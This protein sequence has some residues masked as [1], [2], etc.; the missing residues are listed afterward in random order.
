MNVIQHIKLYKKHWK[1]IFGII[2]I[3]M[4]SSALFAMTKDKVQYNST[5]FLTIGNQ[6][7][8]ESTGYEELQ[9]ADQLTETL[10]GWFRNPAFI[11]EIEEKSKIPANLS[12]RKQEKQNLLITFTSKNE[13]NAKKVAKTT[14]SQIEK[15]LD[16]YNE[17]MHSSFKVA[18]SS[19][20]TEKKETKVIIYIII[21]LILGS[22]LAIGS[23]YLYELIFNSITVHNKK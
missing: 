23:T 16:Q 3:T 8:Q 10:Q 14:I 2:I 13:E 19:T 21:G 9:A 4:I 1:A 11:K 22:I 15:K 20:I 18:L 6:Q 5:L 17:A 7:A 12:A